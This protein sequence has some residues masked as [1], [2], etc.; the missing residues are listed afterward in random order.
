MN[1]IKYKNNH[2]IRVKSKIKLA[3]GSVVI[4]LLGCI[5]GGSFV[6]PMIIG[7]FYLGAIEILFEYN[8]NIQD[9]HEEI[10]P[11]KRK[12]NIRS[13]YYLC[14]SLIILGMFLSIIWGIIGF[15]CS[16]QFSISDVI[17]YAL[18]YGTIFIVVM[19]LTIPLI[20]KFKGNK[21]ILTIS[22]YL[23]M[24]LHLPLL[25]GFLQYLN[26]IEYKTF[27]SS[28]ELTVWSFLI[29]L[30]FCVSITSISMKISEKV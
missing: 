27:F 8:T 30:I 6:V 17:F 28:Y 2:R 3:I 5:V 19:A 12:S 9:K 21:R 24:I 25:K 29:P 20:Y 13:E 1:A 22:T 26:N 4:F 23:I 10:L 14:I 16:F 11:I 18:I 15:V 7:I